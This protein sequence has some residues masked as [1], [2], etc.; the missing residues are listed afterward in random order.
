[1]RHNSPILLRQPRFAKC[2]RMLLVLFVTV[3]LLRSE[4]AVAQEQN[5]ESLKRTVKVLSTNLNGFG[6]PFNVDDESGRF[7]V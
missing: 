2:L 6:I 3:G 4:C 7:E 1:M 5:F